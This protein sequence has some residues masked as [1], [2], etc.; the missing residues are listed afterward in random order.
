LQKLILNGGFVKHGSLAEIRTMTL[1]LH[2]T[3]E[4][5]KYGETLYIGCDF[6]V[7]NTSAT[8]Y[9]RRNGG[10]EWHAVDEFVGVRDSATSAHSISVRYSGHQ[11][12]MYPDSS[13]TARN[14]S[15]T[16]VANLSSYTGIREE[17]FYYPSK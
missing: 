1:T 12:V 10:K 17:G 2:L 8:V 3:F 14:N 7:D 16:R 9:V 15:M 11:V 13:G 5:V 6:N 4:E